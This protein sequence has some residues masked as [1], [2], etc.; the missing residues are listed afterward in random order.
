M[1]RTCRPRA[2]A[3]WSINAVGPSG[4]KAYYSNYGVEQ[5]T[6]AAPGGDRREFYG[7][8]LYGA[9]QTRILAPF[10]NAAVGQSQD[11]NL[12]GIPDIDEDGNP[13]IPTILREP[14]DG[15][16]Y[17]QWIQ[18]TSMASPHAVGV[19]ALIVSQFGTADPVNGGLTMAPAEV[20]KILRATAG[21]VACPE[22]RLFHYPDPDLGG[23]LDA[24]CEGDA[25]FNG[26]YGDGIANALAAVSYTAPGPGPAAAGAGVQAA[27]PADEGVGE[28]QGEAPAR[29]RADAARERQ[30]DRAGRRGGRRGVQGRADRHR[31][32]VEAQDARLARG[33]A[34]WR[35]LVRQDDQVRPALAAQ[36]HA[37]RARDVLRQRRAA[38]AAGG[39]AQAARARSL[40]SG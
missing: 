28:P 2:R 12:D 20:E 18:G 14:A 8:S 35:L 38:A 23:T 11:T 39:A 21:D 34:A 7:S 6:V 1:R 30:A 3:C 22:P 36:P 32:L 33:A 24:T 10:P 40:T 25:A 31:E 37:P 5:S 4:R 17:W 19:A 9:P 26:F 15:D 29:P 27:R 16:T 13:T